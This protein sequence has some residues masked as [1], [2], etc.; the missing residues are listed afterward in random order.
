MSKEYAFNIIQD[1][2]NEGELDYIFVEN[3]MGLIAHDESDNSR[4]M[5]EDEIFL[6]AMKLITFLLN[7]GDFQIFQALKR[8]GSNEISHEPCKG[9]VFE[10]EKLIRDE[11]KKIGEGNFFNYQFVLRKTNKGANVPAIPDEILK[12]WEKNR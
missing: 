4:N 1:I 9:A 3:I 12:L 8:E 5:S 6:S 11:A 2:Y 7:S 10:I